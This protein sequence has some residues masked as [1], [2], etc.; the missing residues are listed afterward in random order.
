MPH[1]EGTSVPC[2]VVVLWLLKY[3]SN[4]RPLC[5]HLDRP[6]VTIL[7]TVDCGH[8]GTM[9]HPVCEYAVPSERYNAA[10]CRREYATSTFPE[11]TQNSL[12]ATVHVMPL[13]IY[14]NSVNSTTTTMCASMWYHVN[15]SVLHLNCRRM[16]HHLCVFVDFVAVVGICQAYAWHMPGICV[17]TSPLPNAK[18]HI[19]PHFNQAPVLPHLN[20]QP[21]ISIKLI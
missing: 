17:P 19:I 2:A 13:R 6:W 16:L 8:P 15:V 14:V 4:G 20:K 10:P 21:H 18:T 12:Y 5:L 3:I 11:G 9:L 7:W 1:P